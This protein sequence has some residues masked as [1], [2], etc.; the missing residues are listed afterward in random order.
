MDGKGRRNKMWKGNRFLMSLALFI[1][2]IGTLGYS[3]EKFQISADFS[4]G[5]PQGVYKENIDRSGAGG[6]GYFAYQFKNSPFSVGLSFSVLVLGSQKRGEFFSPHIPEVE[7]D[8][9]TRNYSLMGH[10]VF[11]F[12]PWK[13]ELRPYVEGLLGFTYL[14]TETGV[15]DQ[16]WGN[17]AIASSVNQRDIAWSTGAGGG[18]LIRIFEKKRNPN[19]GNFGLYIDFGARY[20]FGGKAEYLSEGG[21]AEDGGQMVYDTH[22]SRTDLLAAKIGL[23]FVF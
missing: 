10:L 20:L 16:G 22:L 14:W 3:E 11:R 5:F 8:V 15:Y 23:S 12:Q 1:L 19:R 18:L 6:S 7:V 13:G 9:I 2:S 17:M 4:L 21:I